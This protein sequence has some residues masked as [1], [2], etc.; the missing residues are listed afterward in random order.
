MRKNGFINRV[1]M[2]SERGRNVWIGVVR[3]KDTG[4]YGIPINA[5]PVREVAISMMS[6]DDNLMSDK[7]KQRRFE[8][9]ELLAFI[10]TRCAHA[11]GERLRLQMLELGLDISMYTRK[12]FELIGER[13]C[14]TCQLKNFKKAKIH[15]VSHA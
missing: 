11:V 2:A 10:H 13:M 1:K 8:P 9:N 3:H 4:I 5:K 7:E 15:R 14:H 12:D 6:L